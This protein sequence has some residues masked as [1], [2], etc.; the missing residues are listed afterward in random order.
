[1]EK[2]T[3]LGHGEEP[4]GDEG[5]GGWRQRND[6]EVHQLRFGQRQQELTEERPGGRAEQS[7]AAAVTGHP[8]VEVWLH[9]AVDVGVVGHLW[10]CGQPK[11]KLQQLHGQH[12]LGLPEHGVGQYQAAGLQYQHRFVAEVV[13]SQEDREQ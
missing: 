7:D 1:M 11:E 3:P 6:N 9:H 4:G 2:Q 10:R 5:H 13:C 12:A 8:L